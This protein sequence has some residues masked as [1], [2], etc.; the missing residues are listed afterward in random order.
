MNTDILP[1]KHAKIFN[2]LYT[3]TISLVICLAY[4]YNILCKIKKK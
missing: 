4:L 1:S 2:F 3:D